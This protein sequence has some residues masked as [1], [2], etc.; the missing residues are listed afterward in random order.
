MYYTHLSYFLAAALWLSDAMIL[1][2]PIFDAQ[3]V[4]EKGD[5]LLIGTHTC[6]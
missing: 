4:A 5:K 3:S 1:L 6:V 2:A